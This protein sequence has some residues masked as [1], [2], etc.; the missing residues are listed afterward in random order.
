MIAGEKGL[1]TKVFVPAKAIG[2]A[3]AGAIEPRHPHPVSRTKAAAGMI[4]PG[5]HLPHNLVSRDG[6]PGKN[7]KISLH[8][9]QIGT[10]DAAGQDPD[11][12][13]TRPRLR[14]G[15]GDELE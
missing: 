2:A 13:L 15:T 10:A 3:T 11:Q 8:H 9:M 7:R 14:E 6:L 4:S 12:N 1:R 5:D